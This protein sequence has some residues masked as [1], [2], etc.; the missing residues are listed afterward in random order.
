MS[1]LKY[2]L[3]TGS[4][5]YYNRKDMWALYK[6]ISI[7]KK[8]LFPFWKTKLNNKVKIVS[9]KTAIKQNNL[10]FTRKDMGRANN[11]K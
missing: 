4:N 8:T 7:L 3:I 6:K 9:D 11:N 2:I 10:Q 1:I 5:L